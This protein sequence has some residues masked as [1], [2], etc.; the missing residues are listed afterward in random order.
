LRA[1]SLS[2]LPSVARK[3]ARLHALNERAAEVIEK[4][5]DDLLEELERTAVRP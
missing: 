2:S 1:A 5:V 4:L 3:S